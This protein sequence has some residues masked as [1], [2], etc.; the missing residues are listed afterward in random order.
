M[1]KDVDIMRC[2]IVRD[3]TMT[4]DSVEDPTDARNVLS[5]LGYSDAAEEYFVLVC[6]SCRGG[7][8]GIHELSHGCLTQTIVSMRSVFQCA[9]LNNA[10]SIVVAHNH[11]SGNPEP[12][13]ED[14]AVTRRLVEA[15]K[16]ME[17][18]VVDHIILAGDTNYFSFHEEGLL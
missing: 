7:I 17:I 4:Y 11:P 14:I 18:P 5:M 8:V 1:I 10:A 3:K 12:S 2:K 13:D 15:G 16:L 6:L 9:L